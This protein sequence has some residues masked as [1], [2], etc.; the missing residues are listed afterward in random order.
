MTQRIPVIT[1]K[2][3]RKIKQAVR[4]DRDAPE[5]LRQRQRKTVDQ[6]IPPAVIFLIPEGGIAAR[7]GDTVTSAACKRYYLKAGTLTEWAGTTDLWNMS[8]VD[9]VEGCYVGGIADSLGQY[10]FFDGQACDSSITSD[11]S[12][13]NQIPGVDLDALETVSAELVDFVLAVKDGCLV[14]VAV[15][16]CAGSGSV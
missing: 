4:R 6:E 1:D 10:L 5:N 15:S 8:E 7:D 13:C 11:S 2:G 9:L 14:K 3:Y 16:D 12:F